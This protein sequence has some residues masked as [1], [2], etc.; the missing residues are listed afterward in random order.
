MT[1]NHTL[2]FLHDLLGYD[3]FGLVSNG[4]FAALAG[5]DGGYFDVWHGLNFLEN[6]K[7][8]TPLPASASDETEVKP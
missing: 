4:V 3:G 2:R 8:H 6:V 1:L 5:D 7:V